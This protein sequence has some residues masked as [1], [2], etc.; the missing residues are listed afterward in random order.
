MEPV[1]IVLV[2]DSAV[3]KTCL[4]YSLI[5]STFQVNTPT[6]IKNFTIPFY[7]H[8]KEI[9]LSLWDTQGSDEFDRLR[10]LSYT[11]TNI[12]LLC[13]SIVSCI[14]FDNIRTR[15]YSEIKHFCPFSK[16][17]VI[18]TKSDLRGDEDMYQCLQDRGMNFVA[19]EAGSFLAEDLGSIGYFECSSV[20]GEGVL[21]II[22]GILSLYFTENT[23]KTKNKGR[24]RDCTSL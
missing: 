10:P 17:A 16:F 18:G 22:D 20:T 14:S 2:G 8:D 19:E 9:S 21:D 13:Y 23:K 5:T 7:V 11:D 12:F 6:V 1:K 3:G 4:L 24:R 15:W